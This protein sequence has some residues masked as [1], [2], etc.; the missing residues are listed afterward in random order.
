MTSSKRW[1]A[2]HPAYLAYWNG[3][4]FGC[5]QDAILLTVEELG[6]HL[7]I[8]ARS[9]VTDIKPLERSGGFLLLVR[10]VFRS[11]GRTSSILHAGGFY[12]IQ[13]R[14]VTMPR[15]RAQFPCLTVEQ[16]RVI[17]RELLSSTE[18]ALAGACVLL[19]ITVPAAALSIAVA[20]IAVWV[21]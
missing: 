12:M 5:K 20:I 19:S 15:L 10:V 1:F 13:K 14:V 17:Q 7:T 11:G 16:Q 21:G 4:Y 18:R 9:S 2:W 8:S 6:S 3:E